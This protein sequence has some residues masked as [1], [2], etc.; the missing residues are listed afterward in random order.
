VLIVDDDFMIAKIHRRYVELVDGFEVIGEARSGAAALE[1]IERDRP[2]LVLLDIYLPDLNGLDVLRAVRQ[3]RTPV[4]VLVITAARDVETVRESLR[5]GALHYLIKPFTAEVLSARLE[6]YRALRKTLV[7]AG[8]EHGG[9]EQRQL[10]ALFG[11]R[12]TA[13]PTLPKGL[14]PETFRLVADRLRTVASSSPIT[15]SEC[16]GAVGLARVSARR[17]LE[18]LVE[19]GE[20]EVKLR[21]GSTGRPERLY[22]WVD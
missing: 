10:D 21:Y 6:D 18:H 19:R 8:S 3:S 22:R 9:I 14:S 16:A 1:A 17:Y 4:D 2:D 12:P 13:T 20:V 5:G 11:T 7:P 15:A